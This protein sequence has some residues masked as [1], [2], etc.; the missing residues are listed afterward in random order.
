[1]ISETQE[2]NEVNQ[3]VAPAYCF[4]RV[5]GPQCSGY[6]KNPDRTQWTPGIEQKELRE[7]RETIA[8]KRELA[9]ECLRGKL[10]LESILESTGFPQVFSEYWIARV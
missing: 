1:M 9:G 8:V 7:S 6:W 4:L 3:I 2:T 10:H 5:S